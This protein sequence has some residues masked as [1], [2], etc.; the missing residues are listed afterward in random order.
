MRKTTAW[1]TFAFMFAAFGAAAAAELGFGQVVDNLDLHKNT[2]L[3][4]REYWDGVRGRGLSSSGTVVDV[5]GGR[6]R[7]QVIVANKSR[8]LV[9]GHNI[10]LVVNDEER[11]AR[12]RKG[13]Q[14]RFRGVLHDYRSARHGGVVL[15]LSDAE[16]Q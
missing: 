3:H 7:A 14:V 13:Q 4:V 5:R 11:A 10:V 9:R 15:T 8:R 12:L 16:V 1:I 6:G 2:K